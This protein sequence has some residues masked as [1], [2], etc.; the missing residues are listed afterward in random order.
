MMPPITNTHEGQWLTGKKV[1]SL[2][3]GN[4]HLFLASFVICL[5]VA[6]LINRYTEPVYIVYSTMLID[7]GQKPS[8]GKL[9]YGVD[10]FSSNPFF[11]GSPP[12][13]NELAL[14]KSSAFVNRV[15]AKLDFDVSY[16]IVGKV[17]EVEN[18]P[19]TIFKVGK[20]GAE[21]SS[22][23]R[24]DQQITDDLAVKVLNRAEFQLAMR[25]RDSLLGTYRFGDTVSLMGYAF[26]LDL[27]G[28]AMQ[29]K[30]EYFFRFNSPKSLVNQYRGRLNAIQRGKDGGVV[31]FSI[32]STSPA[33]D[34]AFVN[35][36]M[37]EYLR[38]TIDQKTLEASKII[39]FINR[40]LGQIADSL[41]TVESRLQA[42][43]AN[44]MVIESAEPTAVMGQLIDLQANKNQL[45]LNGQYLAYLE[46][47]L[48]QNQDYANML[49]PVAYGTGDMGPLNE[50]ISQLIQA[51]IEKNAL[52]QRGK[53][54]NPAVA[55]YN[56]RL[57]GLRKNIGEI[58]KN[59]KAN[60]QI[61]LGSVNQQ[62]AKVEREIKSI[63]GKEKEMVSIKRRYTLNE[64]IY[65][66]LLNKEL[67]AQIARAAATEDS[68]ILERAYLGPMIQ[69]KPLNNY[70]I[71]FL[72]GLLAPLGGLIAYDALRNTL[73][74]R[75]ELAQ[76]SPLPIY[77]TVVRIKEKSN[78]VRQIADRPKSQLAEAFRSIRSNLSF[79]ATQADS[80]IFLVTSNLSGEGKSFCSAGLSIV[81]ASTQK[82]SLLI[83]TDLRKPR[84]YLIEEGYQQGMVGLSNYLSGKATLDDIVQ[85]SGIPNLDFIAA[86]PIPPNPTELLMRPAMDDLI[87]QL[88]NRY[89]YI[90]VDTAPVGL[91]SDAFALMKHADAS[92]FVARQG[93][94]PRPQIEYVNSLYKEGK[95]K[96]V[97]FVLNDVPTSR[98]YGY[99]PYRYGG[100]GNYGYYDDEKPKS[101]FDRLFAQFRRKR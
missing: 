32:N 9:L 84:L 59:L 65:L 24:V 7:K 81:L 27:V 15:V 76:L 69:P 97:G 28:N 8:A 87:A 50:L 96:N 19:P 58:V 60:L 42:F 54:K 49:T 41:T 22:W 94:T 36:F 44:N 2:V 82:K 53:G 33:K 72:V 88:K 39:S 99:G 100:Y 57:D 56:L 77:G 16:F 75:E 17:R 62:I 93:Y 14:F 26:T 80:N 12:L 4:L 13:N 67:E 63:P 45:L 71:A 64:N 18:Y 74:N 29:G 6:R 91:V 68:Q 101:V 47:Y 3:V 90:V 40:Q 30:G 79:V 51:Q 83:M 25:N 55:E 34:I 61:T 23:Q 89:A 37:E 78:S 31:D 21:D 46:A 10:M 52:S 11:Y 70:L 86:G 48:A 66:L 43:K 20:V 73:R 35:A 38:Y 5:G 92:L 98:G 85:S 1:F 95:I